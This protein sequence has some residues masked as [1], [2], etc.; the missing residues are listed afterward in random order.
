MGSR[1]LILAAVLL[2]VTRLAGFAGP[3]SRGR[4]GVGHSCGSLA[5]LSIGID[6]YPNGYPLA[7]AAEDARRFAPSLTQS[8]QRLPCADSLKRVVRVRVLTD[9]AATYAGVKAQF[10]SLAT[11]KAENLIVMFAGRAWTPQEEGAAHQQDFRFWLAEGPGSC[12][13]KRIVRSDASPPWGCSLPGRQLKLWLDRAAPTGQLLILDAGS[14]QVASFLVADLLERDTLAVSLGAHNRVIITPRGPAMEEPGG[15]L[16]T[17]LL[18]DERLPAAVLSDLR[19]A[20]DGSLNRLLVQ[21][22]IELSSDSVASGVGRVS[23]H[24]ASMVRFGSYAN[25]V[26]ERDLAPLLAAG[27]SQEDS[28]RSRG[29]GVTRRAQP[30]THSTS[31]ALGRSYALI[32]GTDTYVASG[33]WKPLSNPVFDAETIEGELRNHFGFETT[34]LRNATKRELQRALRTLYARTYSDSDEVLVFIAGHGLFDEAS[35]SGALVLRDTRSTKDDE[36]LDSYFQFAVLRDIVD[37]I[38]AK[39]VV[40]ILDVCFGGVFSGRL[41]DAGRRGPKDEY[42]DRPTDE[43]IRSML[44]YKTR[45]YFTSGGKE[46]VPDGRPGHHSPFAFRLIDALRRTSASGGI[47]TLAQLKVAVERLDPQP[48]AGA[49]GDDEPGGDFL[50]VTR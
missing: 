46:Y 49:F 45:Q 5:V 16:L 15:G 36:F 33:Q 17:T 3:A 1:K 21:R 41:A 27:Q 39:H 48:R 28:S 44:R 43:F 22:Q 19:D 42:S 24:L 9:S 8:W 7:S 47:L 2:S 35:Q 32:V 14:G 23:S 6:K 26:Y 30:A 50:F 18:M 4:G 40:V 13:E 38:P 11:V 29:V 12:P 20:P 34:L 25:V 37:A 31:A 10:D